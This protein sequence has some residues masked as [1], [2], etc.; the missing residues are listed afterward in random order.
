MVERSVNVTR[1]EASQGS[2][3]RGWSAT[4]NHHVSVCR[5]YEL[6]ADLAHS[7]A[8]TFVPSAGC[9][10]VTLK[11]PS[12]QTTVKPS[13]STATI[14]PSLP[15][16]PFGILRRQ[17]LGVEDLHGLAVERRPGAGRRIAA[18]D[19]AIDLLPRLAPVDLGV[20]GAAAAFVGRLRLV[21]FDARRLAGL[22]QVDRLRASPRRPSGTGGRN[23]P[24]RACRCRQIGVFFWISTSP[25]SSPL[26][27][28]KIDSP[29]SFSPL[30]IGQ[31]IALA[32]R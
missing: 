16:M 30:M 2:H 1:M 14:S 26:S 3:G 17:R 18:A 10:R 5:A 15:A 22:H 21:L 9:T 11:R 24:C 28:Q 8:P 19:Q 32:P 23:R 7:P 25:V 31:L 27:G 13:A 4:S 6:L 20:V 12:A 29:V